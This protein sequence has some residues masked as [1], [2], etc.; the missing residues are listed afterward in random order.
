MSHQQ[1]HEKILL[2]LSLGIFAAAVVNLSVFG[3][4][5]DLTSAGSWSISKATVATLAQAKEELS[6]T[7]Y[8]S[9]KLTTYYPVTQGLADFLAEYAAASGGKVKVHVVD[10]ADTGEL[11]DMARWGILGNQINVV[12]QSQQT[13]AMVYSGI[14]IRYLDRQE[15]LP[16]VQQVE[17]LEYDLTSHIDKLITQKTKTY[18]LLSADPAK[19]LENTYRL[20]AQT[21]TKNASFVALQPG[22]AIGENVTAVI[23]AGSKGITEAALKPLDDYLMKGGKLLIAADGVFVDIANAQAAAVPA[24]DNAL[25]RAL[26]GWGVQVDQS[27]VLDAYNELV[28]FQSSQGVALR[29]YPEWVQILPKNTS[30]TNPVTSRFG[31]LSLMWA[32]PLTAT[33]VA[34]IKAENL[35]WTSE[36]SW[37]MKDNL[38]IDPDQSARTG[39]LPGVVLGKQTVVMALTG[40]FASS[41]PNGG[42]S[43]ATRIVVAGSS[44]FLT[45]LMQMIQTD[46]NA[47]FAENAL[48]WLA[49]DE[50]LL[51]IKTRTYRDKNLTL[52]QD[53]QVRNQAAFALSF[54]NLAFVPLLVLGWGLFRFLRRRRREQD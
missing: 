11:N 15:V 1:T 42:S 53:P 40:T 33:P 4:R 9:K 46:A 35:A 17:T 16:Q 12:E 39:V 23:V 43:P 22:E 27:L 38:T 51:S 29:R 25:L 52:L 2:W 41:F 3:F 14:L 50:G 30:T 44:N 24:G 6:I 28:Q 37:L 10:P 31:G 47:A 32:S 20:L 34:G 36:K 7:Y 49:Q 45:D 5:L 54:V 18:A 26:R 8:L 19:T 13:Q 48:G 21:L